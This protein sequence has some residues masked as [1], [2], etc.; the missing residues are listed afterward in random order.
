MKSNKTKTPGLTECI[1]MEFQNVVYSYAIS[2]IITE[3]IYL[4]F[5]RST[6]TSLTCDVFDNSVW[7]SSLVS[8]TNSQ[9]HNLQKL[10]N[11]SLKAVNFFATKTKVTCLSERV[12]FHLYIPK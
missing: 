7:L 9:V 6:V 4:N 11:I 3:A 12:F 10:K 2:S 5:N 1:Q 8:S